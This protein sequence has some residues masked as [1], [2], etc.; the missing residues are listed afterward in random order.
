M[1][2]VPLA[3][4]ALLG[5]SAAAQTYTAASE[6]SSSNPGGA[7]SYGYRLSA[8][9]TE[10]NLFTSFSGGGFQSWNRGLSFPNSYPMVVSNQTADPIQ[11]GTN[12][13]LL[14]G[15]MGYHPGPNGELCVVR[16]TAPFA[17]TWSYDTSSMNLDKLSDGISVFVVA[18]GIVKFSDS[19]PAGTAGVSTGTIGQVDLAA[20]ESI[21]FVCGSVGGNTGDTARLIAS[22][23]AVP[24]PGSVS[25]LGLTTLAGL[26]RRRA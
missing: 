15:E 26:R 4:V 18:S 9:A 7:W 2:F 10:L 21:D 11:W 12:V 19:L 6:F 8:A 16:F 5:S 17:G 13:P 23:T 1:R 25:L 24:T 20:G 14:A 3:V 22:V